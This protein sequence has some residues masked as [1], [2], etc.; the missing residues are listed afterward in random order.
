MMAILGIS[1]QIETDNV[2]ACV[3]NKMQQ[4]F[5]Y[6]NIKHVMSI[7]YNP[8]GQVVVERYNHTLKKML[9]KQKGDI[10]PPRDRLCKAS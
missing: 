2:P 3:P 8:T 5:K 10:R 7:P 6:Y 4:F 9:I 1:L